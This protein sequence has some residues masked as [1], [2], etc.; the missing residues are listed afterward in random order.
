M[1]SSVDDRMPSAVHL[2]EDLGATSKM[3]STISSRISM[4]NLHQL[5]QLPRPVH[6]HVTRP[7]RIAEPEW[8]CRI[9]H[10][11]MCDRLTLSLT[12]EATRINLLLMQNPARP[13]E[14]IAS[15][16]AIE[17]SVILTFI[18]NTSAMPTERLQVHTPAHA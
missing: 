2:G 13:L 12:R 8:S 16:S 17:G 3:Q 11:N 15:W 18:L 9:S 6:S 10:R 7:L 4:S 5:I 14:L 1:I